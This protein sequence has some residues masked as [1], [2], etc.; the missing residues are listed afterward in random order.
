MLLYREHI[1]RQHGKHE[2]KLGFH[3]ADSWHWTGWKRFH[4]TIVCRKKSGE[5]TYTK[6]H[7]RTFNHYLE[8]IRTGQ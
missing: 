6:L 8:W 2:R 1:I 5:T 4:P 7:V 3:R